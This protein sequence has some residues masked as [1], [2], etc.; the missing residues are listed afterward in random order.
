MFLEICF[1]LSQASAYAISALGY[2]SSHEG[3][4]TLI[5]EAAEACNAPA[6]YLA[7]IVNLLSHEKLVRTQRGAGGGV[8]LARPA[9]EISLFEVCEALEDDILKPRCMLGNVP[10]ADDRACPAHRVCRT[11]RSQIVRFLKRTTVADI[12]RF[13]ARW[14]KRIAE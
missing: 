4:P 6:A 2:V 14:R 7:K 1:M 9:D 5:K 3:Q 11:T 8:L 10:C 13:D 12:A